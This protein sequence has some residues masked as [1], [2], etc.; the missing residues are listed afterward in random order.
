MYLPPLQPVVNSDSYLHGDVIVHPQAAIASGVILQ[1]SPD[2]Q[3]VIEE[4]VCLGMGVIIHAYDGVVTVRKGAIL[5]AG[6]LIMGQAT[7]GANSCVG[8]SCTLINTDVESQAAI[9]PGTLLGDT[10]RQVEVSE[11]SVKVEENGGDW[12][13]VEEF[14]E[15]FQAEEKTENQQVQQSSGVLQTT[16]NPENSQVEQS[17]GIGQTEEKT[18]ESELDPWAIQETSLEET[19][20]K[21]VQELSAKEQQEAS[22]SKEE[23]S[24][25][26]QPQA[27][28]TVVGKM[29]VNQLLVTLFPQ[30]Q[31]FKKA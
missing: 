26:E 19:L 10:S 23:I 1:A 18:E 7:V 21:V 6:V 15:H 30:N 8:A 24:A 16:E 20:E 14:S 2:S 9:A 13:Q 22:V 27:P 25:K 28:S 5:G 3:I 29:Y 31:N 17:S 12:A 11:E 4:E